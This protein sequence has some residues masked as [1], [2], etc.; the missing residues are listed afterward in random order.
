MK[1]QK[2]IN[3]GVAGAGKGQS[4]VLLLQGRQGGGIGKSLQRQGKARATEMEG[5]GKRLSRGT[6]KTGWGCSSRNGKGCQGV[7]DVSR[8]GHSSWEQG[9]AVLDGRGD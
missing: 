6:E 4:F 5:T 8:K 7:M 9:N 1:K 2:M 3:L